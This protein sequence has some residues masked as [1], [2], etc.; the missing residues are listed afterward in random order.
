MVKFISELLINIVLVVLLIL[1]SYKDLKFKIIPNKYTMPAIASGF[2]LMTINSGFTGLQ[3]SFFGFLLG[4]LIFLI[5]V[6]IGFMGAGDLK[7]MA[8]IGA[9]KGFD[10]TFNSLLASGIAGGII[11]IV[12]IIY[13]RQFIKTMINM[14]GIFIRPISKLLYLNYGNNLAKKIFN[15]FDGVKKD[16]TELY[17]PYALPIAIGTIVILISNYNILLIN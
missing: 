7:L 5:P 16:N 17:I 6:L 2:I 11:V 9:L 1:T 10:F 14:F 4:F 3:N 15:Y 8:A 12:Y 13:K